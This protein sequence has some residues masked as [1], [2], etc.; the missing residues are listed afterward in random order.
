MNYAGRNIC[1]SVARPPLEGAEQPQIRTEMTL[2]SE[3][4]THTVAMKSLGHIT[5]EEKPATEANCKGLPRDKFDISKISERESRAA[6][7][8]SNVKQPTLVKVSY[9]ASTA[10]NRDNIEQVLL[11]VSSCKMGRYSGIYVDGDSFKI[12]PAILGRRH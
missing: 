8:L 10:A 4:T 3:D 7:C 2:G 9:E 11:A 12:G 5:V 6:F 1:L